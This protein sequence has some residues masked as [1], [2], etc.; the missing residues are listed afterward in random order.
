MSRNK[1]Q[2]PLPRA[3]SKPCWILTQ[4]RSGSNLLES[5]MNQSFE[6]L[7]MHEWFGQG[8]PHGYHTQAD[9]NENPTYFQHTKLHDRRFLE[10][11]AGNLNPIELALPGIQYVYLFR[12]DIFAR[13]VSI[14]FALIT[15]KWYLLK[16]NDNFFKKTLPFDSTFL[17][18]L[19]DKELSRKDIWPE[20]L[21]NRKFIK[22]QYEEIIQS[23]A[24]VIRRIGNYLNLTPIKDVKIH[25]SPMTRSET[26]EYIERL[27]ELV[28]SRL[29]IPNKQPIRDTKIY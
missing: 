13:T 8:D 3:E 5:I 25:S 4:Q 29:D 18:R 22:V 26:P 28:Q 11:F 6:G 9:F 14:Y 16:N 24:E 7:N 12:S 10:V 20:T 27:K 23:P 1:L 15:D 2:I 21:K 19:Y 17:L